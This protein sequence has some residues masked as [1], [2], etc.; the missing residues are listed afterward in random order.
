M[1]VM[2]TKKLLILSSEKLLIDDHPTGTAC[3]AVGMVGST[4]D[5]DCPLFDTIPTLLT[6]VQ[7]H[8][9]KVK[10]YPPITLSVHRP[11]YAAH[12]MGRYQHRKT[13]FQV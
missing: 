11:L 10:I 8:L 12:S 1:I 2:F 6:P 9:T 3:K 13:Y 7:G 5:N 4:V